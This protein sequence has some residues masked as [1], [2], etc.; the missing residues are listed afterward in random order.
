MLRIYIFL[1]DIVL[2]EEAIVDKKMTP[3]DC[4]PPKKSW[5]TTCENTPQVMFVIYG[6]FFMFQRSVIKSNKNKTL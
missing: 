4:A 2:I 3:V 6:L 1:S 5:N